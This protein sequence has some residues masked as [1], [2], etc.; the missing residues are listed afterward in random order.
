MSLFGFPRTPPAALRRAVFKGLPDIPSMHA[1][2][3]PR[4][5]DLDWTPV[6]TESAT[7]QKFEPVMPRP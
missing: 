3:L 5:S 7:G 4:V 1:V 6:A 2:P